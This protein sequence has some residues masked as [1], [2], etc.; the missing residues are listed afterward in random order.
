[1]GEGTLVEVAEGVGV[2]GPTDW[3][4][5]GWGQ[6]L[7]NASGPE[8]SHGVHRSVWFRKDAGGVVLPSRVWSRN[9]P[10]VKVLSLI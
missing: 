6:P 9:T 2:V 1:M 5:L 8:V 10:E 7:I 3:W 4:G